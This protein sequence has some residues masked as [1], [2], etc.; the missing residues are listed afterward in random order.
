MAGTSLPE[1]TA[2]LSNWPIGIIP[3]LNLRKLRRLE[4][5]PGNGL[6]GI[7]HEDKALFLIPQER[8]AD[9]LRFNPAQFPPIIPAEEE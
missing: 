1:E 5:R 9:F 2:R 8:G 7:P 3:G 4:H 6:I